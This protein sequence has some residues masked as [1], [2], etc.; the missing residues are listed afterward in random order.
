MA[1]IRASDAY[2]TSTEQGD[3]IPYS[4]PSRSAALRASR[5]KTHTK[6]AGQTIHT[7]LSA[8]F[9]GVWGKSSPPIPRGTRNAI[10]SAGRDA[11]PN[12]TVPAESNRCVLGRLIGKHTQ[13]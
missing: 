2:S 8:K 10:A 7:P 12:A 1:A 5:A 6:L 13:R 3:S 9:Q 11:A 4:F